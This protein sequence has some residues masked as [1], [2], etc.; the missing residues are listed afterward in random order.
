MASS[1][2]KDDSERGTLSTGQCKREYYVLRLG[3]T[4]DT[5]SYVRLRRDQCDVETWHYDFLE[6]KDLTIRKTVP[7]LDCEREFVRAME[8]DREGKARAAFQK[9]QAT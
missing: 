2:Q 5:D 6:A 8:P 1:A 3:L 9:L 4:P 7:F